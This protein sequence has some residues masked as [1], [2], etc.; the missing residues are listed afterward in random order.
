MLVAHALMG[1][2]WPHSMGLAPCCM[3]LKQVECCLV[4][5]AAVG[6][7]WAG[8]RED[9]LGDLRDQTDPLREAAGDPQAPL[10]LGSS[11]E[12][13]EVGPAPIIHMVRVQALKV[14]AGGRL[15]CCQA[16]GEGLMNK[17]GAQ[18][19]GD[20]GRG[21]ACSAA[22]AWGRVMSGAVGLHHMQEVH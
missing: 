8:Y 12:G 9:P 3:G 17:E 7:G 6:G 15:V 21:A 13:W 10:L 22:L 16:G 1:I 18:C 5:G 11:C 4:A 2:T 19:A 14:R 20:S